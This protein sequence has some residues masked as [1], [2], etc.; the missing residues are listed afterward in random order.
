MTLTL[1]AYYG[2]K[3]APLAA[4]ITQLQHLPGRELR[5]AFVPYT[6]AQVHATII[7]LEGVREGAHLLNANYLQCRRERKPM[8]M[9][10]VL[11]LLRHTPLLP[12]TIQ[13]GGY[14]EDQHYPFTSR[15]RHPYVRSFALQGELAVA[16][17]WPV[18][19]ETYPPALDQLRRAFNAVHVLHKYHASPNDIDNDFFFVLGRVRR[20]ALREDAVRAVEA[21]LRAFLAAR[22]PL[23]FEVRR[24]HLALVTYRDPQLPPASCRAYPLDAAEARIDEIIGSVE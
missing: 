9:R 19:H 15:G 12:M 4:L 16:M 13:L 7:G 3:P 2:P 23:V 1:V 18:I 6:L 14:R 11:D 17:G 10:K 22:E 5:D 8:D 20:A 24:E 21:Q